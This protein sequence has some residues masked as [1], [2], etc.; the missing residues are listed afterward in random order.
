MKLTGEIPFPKCHTCFL[1]AE[2]LLSHP[3]DDS[4]PHAY[5]M[6]C[7]EAALPSVSLLGVVRGGGGQLNTGST[8]LHYDLETTVYDISSKS[9][10][11]FT[12]CIYFRNGKRWTNFPSLAMQSRIF[13][14]GRIFGITT[15]TPRLAI[16]VDDVYFIPNLAS[17]TTP[18]V[19]PTSSAGKQTQADRWNTRANP[20][21]P[22]KRSRMLMS[23]SDSQGLGE[24]HQTPQTSLTSATI[25]SDVHV[26]IQSEHSNEAFGRDTTV[27]HLTPP[28]DKFSADTILSG[29][30]PQRR[31]KFSKSN[32]TS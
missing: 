22:M 7:P 16:G 27:E 24:G 10:V 30:Q 26:P 25:S 13:I 23:V 9:S 1:A 11:T 6:H 32:L 8:L 17:I 4:D 12:V 15:T 28:E 18:P 21:T 29:S 20:L 2:G 31:R 14:D 5:N 3:G 19:T